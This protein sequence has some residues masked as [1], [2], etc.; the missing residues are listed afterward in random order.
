MLT[1][2]RG[3][4]AAQPAQ[5]HTSALQTDM[6]SSPGLTSQEGARILDFNQVKAFCLGA[7]QTYAWKE[8]SFTLQPRTDILTEATVLV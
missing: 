4:Q 1:K 3:G 5:W 7:F 8:V 2:F 6:P